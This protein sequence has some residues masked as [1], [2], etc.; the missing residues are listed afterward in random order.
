MP[1]DDAAALALIDSK[2]KP[3]TQPKRG[4][5]FCLSCGPSHL[6]PCP[7]RELL[8]KHNGTH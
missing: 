4:Q 6:W 8:D 2:H 7:T 3:Y 5:T 1:R